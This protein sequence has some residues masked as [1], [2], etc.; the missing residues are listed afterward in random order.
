MEISLEFFKT[1]S[2]E[3]LHL[4]YRA[5]LSLPGLRWLLRLRRGSL[6]LSLLNNS[7]LGPRQPGE[8]IVA[9]VDA[10]LG[11]LLLVTSLLTGHLELVLRRLLEDCNCFPFLS[12]RS[13]LLQFSLLLKLF[14]ERILI[15]SAF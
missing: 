14:D 11:P 4:D 2:L 15:L 10:A 7:L 6:V 12:L 13:L 9:L 8:N 3:F 1:E 5:L